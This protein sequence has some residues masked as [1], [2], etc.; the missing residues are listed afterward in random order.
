MG[1]WIQEAIDQSP[2]GR[3]SYSDFINLALYSPQ[4]GYYMNNREKIGRLGDFYTTSNLAD[5]FGRTLARW[6]VHCVKEYSLPPVFCEIGG[7]TGR[8]A[9]SILS[10]IRQKEPAME[11]D[12]KYFINDVSPFHRQQQREALTE[13]KYVKI[14][15]SIEKLPVIEGIIF[16][17]ELYDAMPVHV[18]EK[19]QGQLYEVCISLDEGK[20]IEELQPLQN[21]NIFAFL[22]DQS[23]SLTEG[24]R[25]EVPL[26]M[27]SYIKTIAEH[28]QKGLIVTIDYGYTNEEWGEPAHKKGSLRGYQ[29][30]RMFENVLENPGKMDLTTHI[31]FDALAHYGTQFGLKNEQ[32]LG[33]QEFLLKAGILEEL[34]DHDGSNPFSEIAK[35]NRA[36]RNLVVHGGISSYFRVMM[37]TKGIIE[38]ME[39]FPLFG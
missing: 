12:L 29:N 18:I 13:F 23:L 14:I 31:H 15:E 28:L 26:A 30:H 1:K 37:Q 22:E 8:L 33:Q 39:S 20:L 4:T 21:A 19:K 3:I 6:F 17:N 35:R 24:Q 27:V 16:S 36:I 32:L 9:H 38:S 5:A 2:D 10:Y 7:G 34:C 11:K 25:F